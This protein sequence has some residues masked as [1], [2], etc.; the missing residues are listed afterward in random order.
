MHKAVS[1]SAWSQGVRAG[2]REAEARGLPAVIAAVYEDRHVAAG[3]QRLAARA[4]VCLRRLAPCR[5]CPSQALHRLQY[6]RALQLLRR[7]AAAVQ[8]R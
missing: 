6:T 7:P 1:H 5:C 2:E 3:R 8:L 4:R